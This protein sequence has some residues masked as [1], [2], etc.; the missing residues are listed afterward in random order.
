VTQFAGPAAL[1]TKDDTLVVFAYD[2]GAMANTDGWLYNT[3]I[4]VKVRQDLDT[5]PI[6]IDATINSSFPFQWVAFDFVEDGYI[7]TDSIY[8]EDDTTVSDIGELV[9]ILNSNANTSYFGTFADN[10]AGG[11]TLTMPTNLKRQF[12]PSGTLSIAIYAD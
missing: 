8:T 7:Y 9:D 12:S 5:T 2:Y 4:E 10:G 11:I 3:P 6:T 1:A